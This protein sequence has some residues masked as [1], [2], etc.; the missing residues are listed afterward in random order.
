MSTGDILSTFFKHE[1]HEK[2]ERV[3]EAADTAANRA[4][5]SLSAGQ[6]SIGRRGRQLSTRKS[7]LRSASGFCRQAT[8]EPGYV[9][10]PREKLTRRRGDAENVREVLN[11]SLRSL[12]SL[13]SLC[14]K[15]SLAGDT[16]ANRTEQSL[17][18]GQSSIGRRGRLRST[19]TSTLRITIDI[20]F[21]QSVCHEFTAELV[22]K[23][24]SSGLPEAG[25]FVRVV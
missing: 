6:S 10:L 4:E 24:L 21:H 9:E 19:R 20:E 8:G 1:I 3:S 7:T 17:S 12:R 14:L 15:I 18:A 11:I 22:C 13:C 25:A 2:D 5:Q 23:Q 16:P